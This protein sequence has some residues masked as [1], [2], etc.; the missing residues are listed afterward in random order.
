MLPESLHTRPATLAI[1]NRWRRILLCLLGTAFLASQS[2]WSQEMIEA[3]PR[4]YARPRERV[5]ELDNL[6][7]E[8]RRQARDLF[9]KNKLGETPGD[10]FAPRMELKGARVFGVLDADP[11]R[12]QHLKIDPF[13]FHAT[14]RRQPDYIKWVQESINRVSGTTLSVDGS[15]TPQTQE[16][17]REFQKAHGLVADGIA[18]PLTE[19]KLEELTSTSPRHKIDLTKTIASAKFDIGQRLFGTPAEQEIKRG[20][21]FLD[22]KNRNGQVS[23]AVRRAE[24]YLWL[25]GDIGADPLPQQPQ[26]VSSPAAL[27]KLIGD[28]TTIVHRG[29][30]LP[31]GWSEALRE[32][33][34]CLRNSDR[35]PKTNLLEYIRAAQLLEHRASHGSVRI[36]SA[37]PH[38]T[39]RPQLLRQLD[40]MNL[41]R[42]EVDA[43][44][45][46]QREMGKV[47]A[48]SGFNIE[49]GTRQ[50]FLD[51]LQKGHND[52]IVLVAHYA[53]GRI[54][55]PDGQ[56]LSNAELSASTRA[57]APERTVILI[58]CDTGA[59][60]GPTQSPGEIVLKNKMALN[61]VAP[62]DPVSALQVPGMLR[63]F[64]IAG[65]T[66]KEA[67]SS[68]GGFLTI[69]QPLDPPFGAG[70][71]TLVFASL[72]KTG[73]GF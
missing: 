71:P 21:I 69:E 39:E 59:V 40:K 9:M 34:D 65:K 62:P 15:V 8:A 33:S 1:S 63:D 50:A 30:D 37:L 27:E 66:I 70:Y 51:E 36:L 13:I 2:A 5:G 28:A 4:E 54:H 41:N 25:R 53:D 57:D 58:S 7:P 23:V 52:Y 67:F 42:R 18:G 72:A 19:R 17:I 24:Q 6:S 38:E 44:Q 12:P 14:D 60:N 32:K 48:D 43:W 64:L 31:E 10:P 46:L 56:T 22:V 3:R 73:W 16:A 29:D 45:A 55:F 47:Q 61:V 11:L 26:A 20:M 49:V 68:L 35:S